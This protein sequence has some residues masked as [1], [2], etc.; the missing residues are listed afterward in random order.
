MSGFQSF[1][2]LRSPSTNNSTDDNISGTPTC[3][4]MLDNPTNG[5]HARQKQHRRQNSTPT[6]FDGVKVPALAPA[7]RQR[8]TAAAAHGHGRRGQSLDIRQQQQRAMWPTG[9]TVSTG[10][11]NTGSATY[12]QHYDMREAQQQSTQARPGLADGLY[13]PFTLSPGDGSLISPLSTP[14]MPTMNSFDFNSNQ[15][16]SFS[17]TWDLPSGRSSINAD[18]ELYPQQ[19]ALSTPTYA[20]FSD[21]ATTPGWMSEGEAGMT[22]G[23]RRSIGP[24]VGSLIKGFENMSAQGQRPIT[25]PEHNMNCQYVG[26]EHTSVADLCIVTFPPTP[27]DTPNDRIE[28]MDGRMSRFSEGYDESMEETLK[29]NRGR[30]VARIQTVFE[31]M[32]QQQEQLDGTQSSSIAMTRSSTASSFQPD[33]LDDAFNEFVNTSA[34]FDSLAQASVPVTPHASD[35]FEVAAPSTPGSQSQYD[36]SSSP[37]Q[38]GHRRTQSQASIVSAQSIA[39]IKIEEALQETGVTMEEIDQYISGGPGAADD[40][41]YICTFEECGKTFGR[42]ENIK[43]HVQT[44]LNDRRYLCEHCKKCFVR[45]HDLK[46]HAKIHTGIKPYECKCGRTFARHD[47]L[48]RHRQRGM[49]IGSFEGAIR[50][51]AKR[52][53]PKKARPGLDERQE[54]AAKTRRKNMSISSISSQADSEPSSAATTPREM[55]NDS[56]VTSCQPS[57]SSLTMSS[58]APMPMPGRAPMKVQERASPMS[59][60][61][62][63]C[64]SPQEIMDGLLSTPTTPAEG[65][66][67]RHTTPPELSQTPS[68]AALP[69][70]GLAADGGEADMLLNSLKME[71]DSM[72]PESFASSSGLDG[73]SSPMGSQ[74]DDMLFS[75]G[76]SD[77]GFFMESTSNMLFNNKVGEDYG[78]YEPDD[79]FAM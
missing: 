15:S 2:P 65:G 29:P 75:Y 58:S 6:A 35:L 77:Q 17:D 24:V 63:A 59:S 26:G 68:P 21:V 42:K 27:T 55:A 12:P 46:R 28:K 72:S 32:R 31:D 49:C 71:P 5:L 7:P 20:N 40:G 52:G 18:Y 41:K 22:R 38:H 16:M 78:L 3:D 10:T 51:S 45:L 56:V 19:S 67:S 37:M 11:N 4:N 23:S 73:S 62:E 57:R 8:Q 76:E 53:R 60:Q 1:R 48:T 25:P 70:L 44:H 9:T 79:F 14:Q 66:I 34:T 74:L 13:S 36:S 33:D 39:D 69:T 61:T 47:A 50:A 64:V 30:G 43:S 54:K